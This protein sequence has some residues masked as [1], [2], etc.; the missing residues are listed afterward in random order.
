MTARTSSWRRSEGEL[1]FSLV[2]LLIVLTVVLVLYLMY[3]G[4]GSKPYQRRQRAACAKN[5][6]FIHQALHNYA[7]D[8]HDRFPYVTNAV[9]SEAPLSLLVPSATTRT[10]IFICPGSN[11]RSLPDAEPFS[12]R[13][14]SYA[15]MMG[16]G[17]DAAADQWLI[18]DALLDLKPKS[19]GDPIFAADSK[20]R[21]GNNHRGHGGMVLFADGRAER[22][23]SKAAFALN[24]PTNAIALNPRP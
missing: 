1:G 14:I 17:R 6:Q 20:Q 21:L 3:F 22:T 24:F 19:V 8:H 11:H 13:K 10:D 7:L 2:E 15:Y 4:A 23:P 12:T 18:A 5:L 9:T 16:L